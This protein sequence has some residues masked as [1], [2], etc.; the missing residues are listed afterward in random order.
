M[1]STLSVAALALS[2]AAS[3]NAQACTEDFSTSNAYAGGANT[4]NTAQF[5]VD[6]RPRYTASAQYAVCNSGTWSDV[7]CDPNPCNS[8]YITKNGVAGGTGT[9]SGESHT[10]ACDTNYAPVGPA[11]VL[12][13]AE[14]WD[15]SGPICQKEI[16]DGTFDVCESGDINPGKLAW[17]GIVAG[18][19]QPGPYKGVP[20]N[21]INYWN[22][23]K[24]GQT[25]TTGTFSGSFN[26]GSDP[27]ADYT[28]TTGSDTCVKT[29]ESTNW[30]K[31]RITI[32]RMDIEA[33]AGTTFVVKDKD[34]VAISFAASTFKDIDHADFPLTFHW[35]AAAPA[36]SGKKGWSVSFAPVP[37]PAGENVGAQGQCKPMYCEIKNTSEWRALE[38]KVGNA[39][40]EKNHDNADGVATSYATVAFVNASAAPLCGAALSITCLENYGDF[41]IVGNCTSSSSPFPEKKD[42]EQEKKDE[43]T[44]AQ[45]AMIVGGGV[46]FLLLLC[47]FLFFCCCKKNKKN[48]VAAVGEVEMKGANP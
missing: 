33:V 41:A 19:L 10:L 6:C 7:T 15:A 14:R 35:K 30:P 43:L 39:A 9:N 27:G 47:C 28:A 2:L 18:Q 31:T 11:A 12:C 44:T 23:G 17:T 22:V 45:L 42:A 5:E 40:E 8:N 4:A 13:T 46:A 25:V 26:D 34:S 1:P 16:S 3:V 37:C 21:E 36:T 38:I 20:A 29:L 24:K 32:D 48:K